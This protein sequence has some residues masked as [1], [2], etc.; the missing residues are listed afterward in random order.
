MCSTAGHMAKMRRKTMPQL[1]TSKG[2]VTNG[3][4]AGVPDEGSKVVAPS[5]LTQKEKKE[6]KQ[7][8]LEECKI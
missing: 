1:A 3:K 2:V 7:K 4:L 5:A 6:Q 8:H